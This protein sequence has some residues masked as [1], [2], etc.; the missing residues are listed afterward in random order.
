[1]I[2]DDKYLAIPIEEYAVLQRIAGAAEAVRDLIYASTEG[3]QRA[4]LRDALTVAL[5]DYVCSV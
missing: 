5:S 4:A 2:T 1:M 3:W